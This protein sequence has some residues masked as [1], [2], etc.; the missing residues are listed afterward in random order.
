[1]LALTCCWVATASLVDADRRLGA[2]LDLVD[3]RGL[4]DAVTVLL[5]ADH[6]MQGADPACT[7]DWDAALEAAGIPFRDEAQGFLYLG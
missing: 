2:W 1:M 5:T 7:G 3:G 4:T 6:G